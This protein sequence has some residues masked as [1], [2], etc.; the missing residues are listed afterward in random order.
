MIGVLISLFGVGFLLYGWRVDS[1]TLDRI[2]AQQ[3][4][5]ARR[6][7]G[8]HRARQLQASYRGSVRFGILA[9]G[10]L[11]VI[12]GGLVATGILPLN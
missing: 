12:A 6:I 4:W 2:A 10:L 9:G 5:I 3:Y 1:A 8:E 7:I 11:F